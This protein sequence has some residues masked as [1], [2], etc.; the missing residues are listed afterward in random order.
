VRHLLLT[1]IISNN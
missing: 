1:I